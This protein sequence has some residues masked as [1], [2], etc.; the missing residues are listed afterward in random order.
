MGRMKRSVVKRREG[1]SGCFSGD[2]AGNLLPPRN[3]FHK[4]VH[5]VNGRERNLHA[6]ESQACESHPPDEVFSQPLKPV[7]FSIVVLKEFQV[8]FPTLFKDDPAFLPV[9]SIE[10]S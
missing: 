9:H 2:I 1:I 10:P 5:L 4:R 6:T 3:T 8:V 7:P